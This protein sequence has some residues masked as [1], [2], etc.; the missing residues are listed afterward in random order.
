[1]IHVALKLPVFVSW[2][3][4]ARLVA[5]GERAGRGPAA[6]AS[7]SWLGGAVLAVLAAAACYL[8][9]LGQGAREI[10]V[11]WEAPRPARPA[12][13]EPPPGQRPEAA[14]SS[15]SA[16]GSPRV[17]A[18][19]VTP[20]PDPSPLP[21][22]R[23]ADPAGPPRRSGPGVG[24]LSVLQSYHL[25]ASYSRLVDL[26]EAPGAD[27]GAPR[28]YKTYQ[29]R[30]RI[31]LPEPLVSGRL[32][33]SEAVLR[34]GLCPGA[35]SGPVT[36]RELSTLLFHSAGITGH[37]GGHAFRAAASAGALYPVE[38]YV[39]A[40]RVSAL[41]AGLYHYGPRDHTLTRLREKDAIVEMAAAIEAPALVNESP[42]V[43]VFSLL[44]ARTGS[45]YSN[46]AF[47]YAALDL[48][49][50]MAN[51]TAVAVDLGRSV[52][53]IG[54]FD[55]SRVERA[56]GIDGL[57][58]GA[59]LIVPLAATTVTSLAGRRSW[60][61]RHPPDR[62]PAGAGVSGLA[63][64][65]TSLD[66]GPRRE[67][68]EGAIPPDP[69]PLAPYVKPGR[70]QPPG[71]W[72][73]LPAPTAG[74]ANLLEVI[75]RRRSTRRYADRPLTLAE[76]SSALYF[77]TS[78]TDRSTGSVNGAPVDL[79]RGLSVHVIARDVDG[80]AQGLHA[81]DRA[82]HRLRLVRSGDL[83]GEAGSATVNQ[84]AIERAPLVVAFSLDLV[85]ALAS[86]GVRSYRYALLDAGRMAGSRRRS[87]PTHRGR[88]GP[89]GGPPLHRGRPGGPVAGCPSVAGQRRRPMPGR[90]DPT[91][92]EPGCKS[93]TT[94]RLSS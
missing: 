80:L 51:V 17:P 12:E 90:P 42:V 56:L 74:K 92:A 24:P 53:P 25:L 73:A 86:D 81:Y 68:L 45:K 67:E 5:E 19:V 38:V 11:V 60:A 88:S 37:R 27:R 9:G 10:R 20:T 26:P 64:W 40:N 13:V 30:A 50:V 78:T 44:F 91:G 57:H 16:A 61:F 48:G 21:G 32:T 65:A 28:P 33:A 39:L 54:R 84:R 69:G 87:S 18:P 77:A 4:A 41:A 55:D 6:D 82:G 72:I 62:L 35:S 31:A 71:P 34:R 76:L 15:G 63:H 46:R 75:R 3:G 14:A 66:L 85:E 1:S 79:S 8:I 29:G 70:D 49:H 59:W 36:L 83:S 22:R 58:E 94:G 2:S 89:A 23:A 43:L 47:R 93:V 52:A 7:L